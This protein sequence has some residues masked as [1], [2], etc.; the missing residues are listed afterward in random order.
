MKNYKEV[1]GIDVSKKTIDAYCYHG[2]AHKE[3]AN[4]I[5]GYKSLVKWVLK[6]CKEDAVF[7]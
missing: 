4:D 2:Q 5:V 1:V 3:F 7:Y 6:I